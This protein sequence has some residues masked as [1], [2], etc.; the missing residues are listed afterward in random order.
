MVWGLAFYYP[1]L[2][3]VNKFW[4]MCWEWPMAF[5]AVYLESSVVMLFVIEAL[6]QK[7]DYPE[8]LRAIAT[9]LFALTGLLIPL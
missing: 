5:F 9:A 6:L 4:I 7:Y 3:I 2:S 8:T 1:I